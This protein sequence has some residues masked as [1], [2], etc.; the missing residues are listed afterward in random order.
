MRHVVDVMQPVP[1]AHYYETQ[2][3]EAA[4][5]IMTASGMYRP[6][7]SPIW[8]ICFFMFVVDLVGVAGAAR[9]V[10]QVR[11]WSTETWRWLLL[12]QWILAVGGLISTTLLWACGCPAT[13]ASETG[14]SMSIYHGSH[15][16][17][18]VNF[19]WIVF[20]QS[21]VA[22]LLVEQFLRHNTSDKIATF[23]DVTLTPSAHLVAAWGF[24]H[25]F[26]LTVF[27]AAVVTGFWST[28][29]AEKYPHAGEGVKQL[30]ARAS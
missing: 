6:F 11:F 23:N 25:T 26:Y 28:G 15:Y 20:G 30:A 12:S 27:V 7:W 8:W 19:C 1:V 21:F 3:P 9:E 13:N 17:P 4:K 16:K 2:D 18:Y 29:H 24:I 22:W 14:E 10:G 5:K